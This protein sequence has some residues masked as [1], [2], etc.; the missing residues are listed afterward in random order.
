MK[1]KKIIFISLLGIMLFC[2]ACN[3]TN[4][5]T[6]DIIEQVKQQLCYKFDPIYVYDTIRCPDS[7]HIVKLEQK[8]LYLFQSFGGNEMLINLVEIKKDTFNIL[9]EIF[10]YCIDCWVTPQKIEYDNDNDWFM[11]IGEGSGTGHHSEHV[12]IVR[13]ANNKLHKL[14]S[15][16]RYCSDI[17]FESDDPD[18]WV[19]ITTEIKEANKM[20]ITLYSVYKEGITDWENEIKKNVYANITKRQVE[21]ESFFIFSDSCN[22]FVWQ[23]STDPKFE[24]V[25]EGMEY[26]P[27]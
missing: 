25:W 26:Y 18:A 23:K 2:Q 8:G 20:R 10:W 22:C 1:K 15:F 21:S 6:D 12:N 7:V 27:W 16:P 17:L 3:G 19:D 24:K 13:V 5:T 11:Y 4:K 14:F 9:D